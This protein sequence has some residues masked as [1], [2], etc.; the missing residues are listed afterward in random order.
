MKIAIAAFAL[1]LAAACTEAPQ[2]IT[3]APQPGYETD[4]WPDQ[5]RGRTLRQGESGRI[6]H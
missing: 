1:G 5:L 2:Q 4:A 6:Y 3:A